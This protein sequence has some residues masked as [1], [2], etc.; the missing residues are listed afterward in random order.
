ML[1]QRIAIGLIAG[2]AWTVA[3]YVYATRH[4]AR[5][6]EAALAEQK[7]D[8]ART[9][10]AAVERNRLLEAQHAENARK[11]D[12]THNAEL[13]A[14]NA[15]RDQFAKRLSIARGRACSGSPAA[16]EAPDPGVSAEPAG[17]GD[18]RPGQPD[19]GNRLRE[20]TKELQA[21]AK[22]CHA[23]AIEVGR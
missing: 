4:E 23:F 22:A 6:W 12:E 11:I 8:A 10:S 9:L 14:A 3:V 2:I 15:S 16:V 18:S 1:W 7:A 17:S 21:Y 19:P 5:I 20:L 13:A